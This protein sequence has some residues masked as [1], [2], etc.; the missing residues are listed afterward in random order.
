MTGVN[1]LMKQVKYT[2]VSSERYSWCLKSVNEMMHIDDD[3]LQISHPFILKEEIVKVVK[4]NSN[5]KG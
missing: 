2:I 4:I 5:N 3:S 1:I